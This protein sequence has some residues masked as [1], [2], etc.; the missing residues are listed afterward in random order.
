[1]QDDIC[2]LLMNSS[3]LTLKQITDQLCLKFPPT[4]AKQLST[5]AVFKLQKAGKVAKQGRKF[6]LI[7]SKKPPRPEPRTLDSEWSY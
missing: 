7:G 2:G 4:V 5:Q 3:G 1:M 6:H